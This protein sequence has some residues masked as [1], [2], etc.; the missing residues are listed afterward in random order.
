MSILPKSYSRNLV[1]RFSPPAFFL[2]L[3][4]TSFQVFLL[5]EFSARFYGNELTFGLVLAAWL[6]WGG[7]G[8]LRAPATVSG[9]GAIS[10]L[11]L[12]VLIAAPLGFAALRFSRFIL[13][14]LPGELTGL[15]PILV[16]A[17]VLTA[18]FNYP[19]GRVFVVAAR[20]AGGVGRAYFWESVGGAAGGLLTYLF[21]IPYLSNWQAVACLGSGASLAALA[22][23]GPRRPRAGPLL[24]LAFYALLWALDPAAERAA[25]SPY[26]LVSSRDS[27]YGKVQIV[28]DAEQITFYD[29][30]LKISSSPDPAAAEE[31][32]HFA[33]LQKPD[34]ER[35]L[36]VGGATGGTLA[37]VLKYPRAVIDYVDLDPILLTLAE[38]TLPPR[39]RNS[40]HDPRVRIHIADGRRFLDRSPGL[41]DVVLLDLPEPA[42]AQINRFYTREFFR[43]VRRKLTADGVLSFRVPAAENYISLDLRRFLASMVATIKAEFPEVAIVPGDAAVVLGSARAL[44]ISPEYLGGQ[45]QRSGLTTVVITPVLLAARLQPLRR[46]ALAQSLESVPGIVNTDD[47]PISYYFSSVLWS[48]QFQGVEASVLKFLGAIPSRVLVAVPLVVLLA[49]LLIP[50]F[51]ARRNVQPSFVM[52]LMGMTTMALEVMALIRFQTIYGNVYRQVALLLTTFMAGLAVG[53]FLAASRPAPRFTRLVVL[54]AGLVALTLAALSALG[55][56][57]SPVLPFVFLFTLG[58]I[59]GDFFVIANRLFFKE[60]AQAGIGYGWDL[61]GS[62]LAAVGMSSILIPLAGLASLA[63]AFVVLNVVILLVLATRKIPG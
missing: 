47:H 26:R 33:L 9:R 30:G 27:L 17:F 60:H 7:L 35:V 46:Q 44:D 42:T 28:R 16:F 24:A 40:L 50:A 15:G 53:S 49:V 37:E 29:N 11:F 58:S 61:I 20:Q 10:R 25:W 56:R 22:L 39:D 6:F 51:R 14:I 13:G 59:G 36:V 54:Q 19:L 45:L 21:L 8:S 57:P 48:T 12:S 38:R 32:V 4:A 1:L 31:A 62:F 3:L 34:S 63:L 55:F 23:F 43:A 52:V 41:Y 2:G 18:V 5:R